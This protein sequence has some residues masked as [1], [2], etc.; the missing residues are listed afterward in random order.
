[1][2]DFV[3]QISFLEPLRIQIPI[4]LEQFTNSSLN[5]SQI[6]LEL[7]AAHSLEQIVTYDEQ[8]LSSIVID[9]LRSYTSSSC[10][11][12]KSSDPGILSNSDRLLPAAYKSAW[13]IPD[14][15]VMLEA[16]W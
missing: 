7:T 12:R 11:A 6:S 1:M 9:Q 16:A 13:R 15:L 10:T 2:P 8:E 5:I 14:Q 3:Y 4:S